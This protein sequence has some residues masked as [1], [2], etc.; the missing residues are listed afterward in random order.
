M[1]FRASSSATRVF[2]A[3][4]SSAVGLLVPS[5]PL[6]GQAYSPEHEAVWGAAGFGAAIAIGDGEIFVGRTGGGVGEIYPSPGSVYVFA[7]GDDGWEFAYT[8]SGDNVEIG[9]GFGAALAV[10]GDR[11]LVGSPGRG[12]G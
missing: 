2:L 10:E 6:G 8:I 12:G 9:D 5:V 4:I 1:R 11:L 7:R 3:T